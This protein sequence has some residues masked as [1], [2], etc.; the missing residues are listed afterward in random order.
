AAQLEFEVAVRRLEIEA[1][2]PAGEDLLL[3][4]LVLDDRLDLLSIRRLLRLVR[5][6]LGDHRLA[7]TLDDGRLGLALL[8]RLIEPR[9]A[10]DLLEASHTLLELLPRL[11]AR[12]ARPRQPG[13][14]AR[15]A[16]GHEPFLFSGPPDEHAILPSSICVPPE[17]RSAARV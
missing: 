6:R 15:Q 16:D 10:D 13:D 12:R 7:L 4:E 1:V 5:R 14:E 11:L 8:A 3:L 2:L 17:G 9:V